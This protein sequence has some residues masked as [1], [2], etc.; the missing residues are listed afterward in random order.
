[1]LFIRTNTGKQLNCKLCGTNFLGELAIVTGDLSMAEAFSFFSDPNDFQHVDFIKLDERTG[2][3]E[4]VGSYNRY[5]RLFD[6][7]YYYRSPKDVCVKLRRPL[8]ED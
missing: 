8:E 4:I 3:E 6:V 7:G 1:M 2:V 5:T